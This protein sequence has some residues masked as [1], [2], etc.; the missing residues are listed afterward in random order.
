MVPKYVSTIC[1]FA[2]FLLIANSCN[3]SLN[4]NKNNQLPDGTGEGYVLAKKYCATCHSF[5]PAAM[6]DKATWSN[7]VLPGMAPHIGIG[8]FGETEYINN[9][10]YGS[11]VIS[12][13]N[14]MKIVGYYTGN[15]PAALHAAVHPAKVVKDWSIFKMKKPAGHLYTEAKTMLV[16]FDTLTRML[17]TSDG[18][19]KLI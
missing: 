5:V 17:Y 13:E 15:A 16:S 9:P 19:T 7:R 14:W 1:I 3:L 8:V 6:L 18:N 12:F 10:N 2:A 11:G 4:E